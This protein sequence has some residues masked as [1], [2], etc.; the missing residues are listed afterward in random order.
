MVYMFRVVCPTIHVCLASYS[1]PIPVHVDGC[2]YLYS[3][4]CL[5][6]VPSFALNHVNVLLLISYTHSYSVG[7][8]CISLLYK[9]SMGSCGR[10]G[11][12]P[13]CILC[14]CT[15]TVLHV[16]ESYCWSY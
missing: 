1:V 6:T 3:A 13:V 11:A 10:V 5:H 8:K 4:I 16:G 9:V 2:I 12:I 15:I 14:L 7:V